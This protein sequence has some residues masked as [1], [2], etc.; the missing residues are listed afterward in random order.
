MLIL[1][2]DGVL[3]T[4]PSWKQDLIAS[5]GYSQFNKNCVQQINRLLDTQDFEIWLS[6]SRRKGQTLAVLNTIFSNRGISYPIAGLLPVYENKMNRKEEI[7]LFLSADQYTDFLI[8]DDDKS[9]NGLG[10]SYKSKLVL[11]QYLKGFD[12]EKYLEAV[13]KLLL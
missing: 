9:L 1:D 12:Q 5:D 6:S 11:T 8:I 3:I 7:E 4:T 10:L 2:L 13:D